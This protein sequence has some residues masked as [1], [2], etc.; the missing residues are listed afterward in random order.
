MNA[1][2]AIPAASK[3]FALIQSITPACVVPVGAATLFCAPPCVINVLITLGEDD[4][5]ELSTGLTLDVDTDV[6]VTFDP[7]FATNRAA[8]VFGATIPA[9]GS[10]VVSVV[11]AGA[12][13]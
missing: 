3:G 5:D 6:F 2:A 10:Y 13:A 9:S 4:A 12:V 8:G 1:P 7:L 11:V